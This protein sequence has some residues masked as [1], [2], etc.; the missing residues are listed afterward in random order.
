MGRAQMRLKQHADLA[1]AP[2]EP[3]TA[4]AT[5]SSELPAVGVDLISVVVADDSAAIRTLAR[6]ALS[7]SRGF[8]IVAEAADGP[9]AIALVATHRPDC[10]VLDIEMPGMG[11]FEV[12]GALRR[13]S[14]TVPVVLLSG[15]G[16]E[17]VAERAIVGGAA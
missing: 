7:A 14:P 17:T 16:D 3:S 6:Y 4:T 5:T 12:L 8:R 11:G 2:R 1:A 15:H 13:E 10:V 9:E